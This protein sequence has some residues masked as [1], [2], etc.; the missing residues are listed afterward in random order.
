MT[1]YI[2]QAAAT[3][4]VAFALFGLELKKN[5]QKPEIAEAGLVLC[6]VLALAMA[7]I[8]YVV[9]L[10]LD[11]IVE[12]GEWDV[13]LDWEP[14]RLCFIGGGV[15]VWLGIRLV[16]H[17]MKADARAALDAFAAPGALLVAGLRLAEIHLGKLGAGSLVEWTGLFGGLPFAVTDSWGDRYLA[18]FMLETLAAVIIAVYAWR[19]K[20]NRTGV[21]FEKTVFALCLVQVLLENLRNQAMKWGFVYVEQILC[22]VI[23]MALLLLACARRSG[24]AKRF[25]PAVWMLLCMG[26]VVAAEFAR[27]KG[28]SEFLADFGYVLMVGFLVA[29]G[30]IYARVMKG[31]LSERPAA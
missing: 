23:L 12:W 21:R 7:K 26:G 30:V 3:T 15:G 6:T 4:A 20:E 28:S 19:M 8:C 14:K 13:F 2:I 1:G 29:M 31:G 17:I 10:Q 16:A 25:L 27:Q 11:Y 5:G 22:A 18:V 24:G 9:L